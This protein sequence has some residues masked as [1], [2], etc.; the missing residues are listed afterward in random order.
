[1]MCDKYLINGIGIVRFIQCPINELEGTK[2]TS[3]HLRKENRII[4]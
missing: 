3:N 4:D 1:M 2:L